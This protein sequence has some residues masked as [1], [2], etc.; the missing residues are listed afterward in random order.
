MALAEQLVA[1]VSECR[2]AT[3]GW[4]TQI[5][6]VGEEMSITDAGIDKGSR[7]LAGR[8]AAH[9]ETVTSPSDV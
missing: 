8:F 4:P 1:L 7:T 9:L 5:G 6:T 3:S 2:G